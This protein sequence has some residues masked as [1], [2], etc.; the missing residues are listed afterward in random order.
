MW[1]PADLR[2]DVLLLQSG[3]LDTFTIE[4]VKDL[5]DMHQRELEHFKG[6]MPVVLLS[7]LADM[8]DSLKTYYKIRSTS[9]KKLANK[10]TVGTKPK[11]PNPNSPTEIYKAHFGKNPTDD[12]RKQFGSFDKTAYAR[13]LN[14]QVRSLKGGNVAPKPK[15]PARRTKPS[16]Q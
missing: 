9:A 4:E 3:A 14:G 5:I 13:W 15:A 2:F 1:K 12:Y 8:L 6:K 11:V 7:E 10:S 16:V